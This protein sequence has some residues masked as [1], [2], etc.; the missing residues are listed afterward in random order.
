[1][2][3]VWLVPSLI[4][5]WV[6]VDDMGLTSIPL[7]ALYIGSQVFRRVTVRDEDGIL[8]DATVTGT[9]MRT[10]ATTVNLTV[11]R[12]SEGQYLVTFPVFA[13]SGIYTF[14]IAATGAVNAVERG[15]LRVQA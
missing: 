5:S 1:M 13:A 11:A 15:R 9:L 14:R 2:P 3:A 12:E 7:A 4:G 6:S 10:G 8:A